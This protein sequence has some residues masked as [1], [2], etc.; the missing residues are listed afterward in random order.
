LSARSAFAV[1]GLLR[2][3]ALGSRTL[4]SRRVVLVALSLAG[5][6]R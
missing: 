6:Q 1:G 2:S 5:V 3:L 4:A